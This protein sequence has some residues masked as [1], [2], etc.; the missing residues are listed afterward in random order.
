[1][2]RQAN[3]ES[4]RN[5]PAIKSGRSSAISERMA[6]GVFSPAR[7]CT[8]TP[9]ITALKMLISP[10]EAKA[11]I[12]PLNTSP[13]PAVA[14]AGEPD[15]LTAI[16]PSG[17]AIMLLQPL[18]RTMQLSFSAVT[19]ACFIRSSPQ[20]IS[21]GSSICNSLAKAVS[22][23]RNSPTCGGGLSPGRP[24]RSLAR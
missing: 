19:R 17:E 11:P 5:S 2:P 10:D 13:L 9:Q 6:S 7:P 3:G 20:V 22:S 1:M 16:S 4:F 23:P 8:N 24:E 14:S 12:N 18:C 15:E 21:S